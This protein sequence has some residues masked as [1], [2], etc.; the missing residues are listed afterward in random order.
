TRA[1]RAGRTR[2]NRAR[3]R[4]PVER[5]AL[6]P[7]VKIWMRPVVVAGI[8]APLAVIG[9]AALAGLAFGAA[10]AIA[11]LVAGLC[12]LAGVHLWELDRLARWADADADAPVPEGRG[13]WGVALSALYRRV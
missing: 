8:G 9:I 10:W 4:L 3:Q 2:R 7:I 12:A 5:A 13:A 11:V 6:E 1:V